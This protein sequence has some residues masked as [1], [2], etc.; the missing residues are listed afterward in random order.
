MDR[1]AK[2]V[3][4][5]FRMRR[6][7]EHIRP[8][9]Q[10]R[11]GI[12]INPG[13]ASALFIR[14]HVIGIRS[15]EQICN[16][17]RRT[18]EGYAAITENHMKDIMEK[19]GLMPRLVHGDLKRFCILLG[20]PHLNDAND[21]DNDD[22][23]TNPDSDSDSDSDSKSESVESLILQGICFA[24]SITRVMEKAL[25]LSKKRNV[26]EMQAKID[27]LEKENQ[28]LRDTQR[29]HLQQIEK[30]TTDNSQMV[31]ALQTQKD[32]EKAIS[33]SLMTIVA[34]FGVHE[35]PTPAAPVIT[36]SDEQKKKR[37]RIINESSSGDESANYII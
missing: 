5:R 31:R 24:N 19:R 8:E 28:T 36:R 35:S 25:S 29:E 10:T 7:Y 27:S 1:R 33:T 26:D 37:S 3:R 14:L 17:W 23:D 9:L 16:E 6:L 11:F 15:Y 21:D 12:N 22:E 20:L 4:A 30:A 2:G 18:Y 13:R 32:R 34:N